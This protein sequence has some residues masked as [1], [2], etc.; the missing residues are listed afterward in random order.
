MVISQNLP[1]KPMCCAC[2]PNE[3]E[4]FRTVSIPNCE[5]YRQF[6]AI[7][8]DLTKKW[9]EIAWLG[10]SIHQ[11]WNTPLKH[12][13][14]SFR[15]SSN[16]TALFDCFINDWWSAVA[17]CQESLHMSEL[18]WTLAADKQTEFQEYANSTHLNY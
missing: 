15:D 8:V 4:F 17:V 3:T 16:I 18:L 11:Q 10:V 12:R 1:P 9:N 13:L 7:K 14:R 5:E 6:R 2:L